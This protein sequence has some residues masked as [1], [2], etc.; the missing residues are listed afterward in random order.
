M[1]HSTHDRMPQVRAHLP[2]CCWN[3]LFFMQSVLMRLQLST[4][5]GLREMQASARVE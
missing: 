4:S 5:S 3:R 2:R 1:K